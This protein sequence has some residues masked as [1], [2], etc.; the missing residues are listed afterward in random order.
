MHLIIGFL[1]ALA[2]LLFALDRL[3]IDIGW[4]NPWAWNRRRKWRKL[5]TGNPAFALEQP[6]EAIA[7]LATA[8]TKIDGDISLEEK[9]A[10][11]RVFET[12]FNQTPEEASKLLG[13]SV[14]LLG[15]GDEIYQNPQK[16]LEASISKFT[17]EQKASSIE[18]LKEVIALGSDTSPL[19]SEFVSKVEQALFPKNNKNA[20]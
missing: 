6:M 5:A 9:E 14:Y 11:K 13:S 17:S 1:T 19:Q 10:L 3:G 8:S 2:T 7:L 20:W 4:L 12:T 16:V 15:Q 18:L